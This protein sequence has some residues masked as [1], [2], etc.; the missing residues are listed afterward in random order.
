MK[1]HRS[2]SLVWFIAYFALLLAGLILVGIDITRQSIPAWAWVLGVFATYVTL[3]F[4]VYESILG[5]MVVMAEVSGLERVRSEIVL[6]VRG[7]F[8]PSTQTTLEGSTIPVPMQMPIEWVCEEVYNQVFA[9]DSRGDQPARYSINDLRSLIPAEEPE[10]NESTSPSS[11]TNT[12]RYT[13]S[14]IPMSLFPRKRQRQH[15]NMSNPIPTTQSEDLLAL[16]TAAAVSSV[17]GLRSGDHPA[18]DML[19]LRDVDYNIKSA[20]QT[21]LA[22]VEGLVR[23]DSDQDGSAGPNRRGSRRPL[24]RRRSWAVADSAETQERQNSQNVEV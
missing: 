22:R 24:E 12:R 20:V 2:L 1:S 16:S 19:G 11:G 10:G 18:S 5:R 15:S 17:L 4:G 13:I 21:T 3:L 23:R 14:S 9:R 7:H 6:W 8:V